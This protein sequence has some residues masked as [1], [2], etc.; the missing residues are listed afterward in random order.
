L[1]D[2]KSVGEFL[3]ETD[4]GID[5]HL[6]LKYQTEVPK[7]QDPDR[8]DELKVTLSYDI[9]G[10]VRVSVLDRRTSKR[11][12]K[13]IDPEPVNT[14]F[15]EDQIANSAL[16]KPP[17]TATADD[18]VK[19]LRRQIMQL[20]AEL[21]QASQVTPPNIQIAE[22]LSVEE[23]QYELDPPSSIIQ[24]VEKFAPIDKPAPPPVPKRVSTV[25]DPEL[26]L[27]IDLDLPD[28]DFFSNRPMQTVFD[29]DSVV[30]DAL[31]GS[32]IAKAPA[33]PQSTIQEDDND[34]FI[35]DSVVLDLG[36]S[37]RMNDNRLVGLSYSMKLILLEL[38]KEQSWTWDQ[39]SALCNSQQSQPK[40]VFERLNQW[41]ESKYREYLLTRDNQNL[42]IKRELL[43]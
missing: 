38:M 14:D 34:L 2:S 4:K 33:V 5:D 28:D 30:I 36:V 15:A 17:A 27:E 13:M 24:K 10:R 1:G 40:F 3:I 23:L 19:R 12:S 31:S 22:R 32:N 9:T 42:N 43:T 8:D 37:L 35:D 25:Q 7:D 20:R 26:D 6:E 16:V 21:K 41:S 29:D 11:I 39:F 18:D